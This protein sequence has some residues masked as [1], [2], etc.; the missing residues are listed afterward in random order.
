MKALFVGGPLDGQE[1]ELKGRMHKTFDENRVVWNY[2]PKEAVFAS[3]ESVTRWIFMA[4]EDWTEVDIMNALW[5][6]YKDGST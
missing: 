4:P 6:R 2:Y 3:P 5:E 1:K